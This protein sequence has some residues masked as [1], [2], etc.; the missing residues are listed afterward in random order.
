[1][2]TRLLHTSLCLPPLLPSLHQVLH[3]HRDN[4]TLSSCRERRVFSAGGLASQGQDSHSLRPWLRA[5]PGSPGPAR[6]HTPSDFSR[7]SRI[8][9]QRAPSVL[10]PD[11]S[12]SLRG[13]LEFRKESSGTLTLKGCGPE[14]AHQAHQSEYGSRFSP[15]KAEPCWLHLPN[16]TWCHS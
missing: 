14:G 1:M 15:G 3:D 9:G 6:W 11:P 8:E 4:S 12:R 13:V 5:W 10:S 2:V 7:E 16:Q